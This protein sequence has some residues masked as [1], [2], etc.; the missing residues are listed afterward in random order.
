MVDIIFDALQREEQG[1]Q[2]SLCIINADGGT[3]VEIVRTSDSRRFSPTMS[4]DREWVVY[5]RFL[6]TADKSKFIPRLYAVRISGSSEVQLTQWNPMSEPFYMNPIFSPSGDLIACE[7]NLHSEVNPDIALLE[8]NRIGDYILVSHKTLIMNPMR[9][10]NYSPKFLADS[11]RVLYLSNYSYDDLLEVCMA[12]L[13]KPSEPKNALEV[14]W[15]SF[16]THRLTHNADCVWWRPNTLAIEPKSETAFFVWGHNLHQYNQVCSISCK[17]G[18]DQFDIQTISE[19]YSHISRLSISPDGK[20][21]LFDGDY[22]LY[23][24]NFDGGD[25]QQLTSDYSV[26]HSHPVFSPDGGKIAFVKSVNGKSDLY[27]MN[28]DGLDEHRITAV[29]AES[30][31]EVLWL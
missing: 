29:E 28:R 10:G 1:Y 17:P 9:I 15:G 25:I 8:V 31:T 2:H 23:I 6:Y 4:P 24:M 26:K 19:N 12:D 13:S 5:T 27:V 18:T 3:S 20:K 7:F 30:I 16:E 22:Q 11:K 14:A 21:I